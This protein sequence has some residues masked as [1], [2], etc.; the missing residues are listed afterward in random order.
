ME[1]EVNR[2]AISLEENYVYHYGVEQNVG[3]WAP[4]YFE[5]EFS[6]TINGKK[7]YVD[8]EATDYG[9]IR[10]FHIDEDT[11][12]IG[13]NIAQIDFDGNA[14]FEPYHG[15]TKIISKAY[16]SMKGTKELGSDSEIFLKLPRDATGALY[17]YENGDLIYSENL[18]EGYASMSL[19]NLSVGSHHI[20][21]AYRGGNYELVEDNEGDGYY[22]FYP[23]ITP[24]I[25]MPTAMIVGS[26]A[27]L[28]VT[29]TDNIQGNITVKYCDIYDDYWDESVYG[30]AEIMDNKATI[31]LSRLPVGDYTI[32][33]IVDGIEYTQYLYV[34]EDTD[35]E[36]DVSY[37]PST[38]LSGQ[39]VY[40][41][42]SLP[43]FAKGHF[44]LLVDSNVTD[45]FDIYPAMYS[46][47]LDL[48]IK[49]RY[50]A[51]GNHTFEVR[52]I[53][54]E[55][56]NKTFTG[57]FEVTS[58]EI[59]IPDA[60]RFNHV[61]FEYSGDHIVIY[62]DPAATG[63][64][65]VLVDG[66][67]VKTIHLTGND[68]YYYASLYQNVTLGKH[69]VEVRYSGD[70]YH[71]P[72]SK[73]KSVDFTYEIRIYPQKDKIVIF[74]PDLIDEEF[75]NGNL[76]ISI[77]GERYNW[78]S[79]EDR[80][81]ISVDISDLS[82]G[83]HTASVSYAGDDKFY[84]ET[85]DEN[86][87]YVAPIKT[88]LPEEVFNLA[89]GEDYEIY[90]MLPEDATGKMNVRITKYN[91]ETYDSDVYEDVNV[92]FVNGKASYSLAG[93]PGGNYD[94]YVK[95][96]GNDYPVEE[97]FSTY[98]L[99][100]SIKFDDE[101]I[102]F[103]QNK[104]VSIDAGDLN[105]TMKIEVS[106]KVLAFDA[107]ENYHYIDYVNVYTY[108]IPVENG[109]ATYVLSN[110]PFN[111]YHI[112]VSHI[113]DG[114]TEEKSDYFFSV[115]TNTTLP[116]DFVVYDENYKLIVQM[117]EDSIGNLTAVLHDYKYG[118]DYENPD[119]TPVIKTY[120]AS[121][122]GTF[123]I[124]LERVPLGEYYLAVK[125]SGNYGNFTEEYYFNVEPIIKYPKL[126]TAE[127][128]TVTYVLPD[129][130]GSVEVKTH[131]TY[132]GRYELENGAAKIDLPY[133]TPAA[134]Y[135]SFIY[136]NESG[137]KIHTMDYWAKSPYVSNITVDVNAPEVGEDLIVTVNGH[138]FTA[139]NVTLTVNNQTFTKPV[140]M[141]SATFTIPG[142]E[143]GKYP[144]I[145]TYSGNDNVLSETRYVDAEV[146]S[147]KAMV[148]IEINASERI[149]EGETLSIEVAVENSTG[150]ILAF[151]ENRT[152]NLTLVNGSCIIDIDG[153]TVGEHAISLF[154][155][156]DERHF[157]E[158]GSLD[159][160]VDAKI[161]SLLTV[162][163]DSISVGENAYVK[164]MTNENATGNVTVTVNNKTYELELIN[165][166]ADMSI[167][168]LAWGDY[169][170]IAAYPGDR[171][172]NGNETSQAFT[173]SKLPAPQIV[174]DALDSE[175]EG[176][177]LAVKVTIEN[178]T[179]N[180]TINGQ[181]ITLNNSQATTTIQNLKTG[182]LTINVEYLGNN[183]YQTSKA[184]KTIDVY[185]KKD[186]ELNATTSNI[187]VGETA[188]I[189]ITIN[190]EITGN[191][192][193]NN[194]EVE[195]NNG[196]VIYEIS[197]LG[198][199]NYSIDIAFAGNKYYKPT[200][201]TATFTVSKLPAPQIVID[202][203]DSEVEGS[204]L[205][206]KVTI[207]NA[208]GNITINGQTITLNNSQ[209]TTTIQ[210]LKTGTLTINVEYLGNELYLTSKAN[211]TVNVY[212]KKD[213]EL[214]ATAENIKV[215]E[216]AVITITINSEI[217]GNLTVN[218]EEIEIANGTVVYE[219]SGLG[220]GNY[221][222]DIKFAGNK[223][224]KPAN[225]TATFTVSKLPAPQIIIDTLDSEVEGSDLT[226][227]VTI[228]NAT[229]NITI[230]NETITLNNSQATT[231]IQNL[232]TGTL[233]INV[234]YL[235]NNIYL[236]SK[237]NK[238]VNI[239]AKK[240]AELNAT[241]SNIKVGGIAVIAITIN[242]EITG[243]LTVNGEEVEI[244]NGTV[245][246]GISGLKEGNHTIDIAFAGNKYFNA[247]QTSVLIQV[248]KVQSPQENPFNNET[249]DSANPTYSISYPSDATGNLTVTIANR[250]YTTE[251]VNGSASITVT[252]M[253]AGEYDVVVSYSGDDKY[254]PVTKTTK[255]TVKVD[256]KIVA[257]DMTVL[258]YAGK[259]YSVTVY[260]DDG[261]PA[262]NTKVVF[263]LNGK[264]VAST[265]T[266]ANGIAKFKVTQTPVTNGKLVTT[267]LGVSVTKK[268]TVKR[269]IVL[270]KATVKRSA[271]KLILQATLKK[272]NGKYLTNK[273]ITFKFN[274]VKYIGKTGSRGV[275]KVTINSTALLKLTVG[276][277]VTY[278]ATYVKDT[279]KRIVKVKK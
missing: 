233:T 46:N 217:T 275:A 166:T 234:E 269:V 203:L 162:S 211:K 219:I 245:I 35:F 8:L 210:N 195:I 36:M 218:N 193:V 42:I 213:A 43:N 212:A 187:N 19:S 237:A 198:E 153:L 182:T 270:K 230:N 247:A 9:S 58:A 15:S 93:L 47:D 26:D 205:T 128:H 157:N 235:G 39:K 91:Y 276:K 154:Y 113:V 105:G 48:T 222:I 261:K 176:S 14:E 174:I 144:M 167:P 89:P 221:T 274:G 104:T 242:S 161:D 259:Y 85:F 180:I 150:Y 252:D 254:A 82:Y 131:D 220:E 191:L 169:T 163:V 142:L 207:E 41:F 262:A 130:K 70:E 18:T 251:L 116:D 226:V 260:G 112:W 74:L 249:Q 94:I 56:A 84:A 34:V 228:E 55:L 267:A 64:I 160:V 266:N 272:V 246:Y 120:T 75:G 241:T 139:A 189:T 185:A 51:S 236:S 32:C 119:N 244:V 171:Y 78:T 11:L 140:T 10:T 59:H 170:V 256:P 152:M 69:E 223:Y 6:V 63:N 5:G 102:L 81:H 149:I 22:H 53:S 49:T 250:T 96:L 21:V 125:Y 255:T 137:A 188:R 121:A 136:Y 38:V 165:G 224:Y 87:T 31:S 263:T 77:D 106:K 227:K 202:A 103:G 133:E 126:L 146:K 129:A 253:P 117:P 30:T 99:I 50:L 190:K 258:Y 277:K 62:L 23:D 184:N 110:L 115:T 177:D 172:F 271:K 86:F 201:T 68:Y 214:N 143:S 20:Q 114:K 65:T 168:N 123:T 108:E 122:K 238:T 147:P 243:N 57:E 4:Y 52:F 66:R 183:K 17:F 248:T 27:N 3:I 25:S 158:T 156:G 148:E 95:Y 155:S 181:T 135:L 192:T 127:N 97:D 37:D 88:T 229:G 40:L 28:T 12:V 138:R 7:Y 13:E 16:M 199:G 209:A 239:Y 83:K 60:I 196:T 109:K 264:K 80:N 29:V 44:V 61:D 72:A 100:S 145:I 273:K 175:V 124:D 2:F 67:T 265:K 186:S 98:I 194:E 141:G 111:Y 206:V 45:E 159:F 134:Y 90:L 208:T 216:I 79:N 132:F 240:D 278:T 268:L 24:L 178:A 92:S 151:I 118:E 101:N 200:N 204:D 107:E 54:D 197:R 71:D 215:G 33:T 225:T 76:T 1:I 279:V 257:N 232:Q 231:T 179:G 164:V 73:T 173:V